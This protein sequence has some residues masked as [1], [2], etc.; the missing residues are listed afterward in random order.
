MQIKELPNV[1]K[2]A[3]IHVRLPM[4]FFSIIIDVIPEIRSVKELA[5]STHTESE[6]VFL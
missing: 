5:K 1:I 2:T 3:P 4:G 6:L